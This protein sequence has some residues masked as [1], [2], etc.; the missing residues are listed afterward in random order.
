MG[1]A[2]LLENNKEQPTCLQM[3]FGLD[4]TQPKRL[5]AERK[6]KHRQNTETVRESKTSQ[7]LRVWKNKTRHNITSCPWTLSPRAL[8]RRTTRP[9]KET[10]VAR[11]RSIWKA[12]QTKGLPCTRPVIKQGRGDM[13]SEKRERFQK[14]GHEQREERTISK[15]GTWTARRENDFKSTL[16]QKSAIYKSHVSLL[17]TSH[18]S[19]LYTSHVSLIYTSHVSLLYTSHVSL[20]YTSNVSLSNMSHISLLH[21]RHVSLLYTSHVSLSCTSHASLL[22]VS[23]LS[24][25]HTRHVSLL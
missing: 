24:L 15:G 1:L 12:P 21:M 4:S 22:C 3:Q 18:V 10:A 16:D 6:R 20:I 13:N 11:R 25:L 2:V 7:G 23:H 14:G 5:P 19:L 17:Y 8:Q 9:S